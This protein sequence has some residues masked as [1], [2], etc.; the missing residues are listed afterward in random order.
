MTAC[1]VYVH[2]KPNFQI[3]K[4]LLCLNKKQHIAISRFRTNNTHLHKVTGRFKKKKN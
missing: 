3:E 1:D 2:L 4:Y